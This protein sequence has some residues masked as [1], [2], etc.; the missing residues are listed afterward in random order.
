MM[1]GYEAL[2]VR[3]TGESFLDFYRSTRLGQ[4]IQ[5][6]DPRVV[7]DALVNVGWYVLRLAWFAAPWSLAAFAVAA[8]WFWATAQGRTGEIFEFA[9]ARG[10]QWG[11]L[12]TAVFIAVLS[13]ALVRAERYHLPKLFHHRRHGSCRQRCGGSTGPGRL[14]NA[15]IA[16]RLFR[17]WRG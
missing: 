1:A 15:P 5:F 10:I 17:S 12:T 13:P 14:P 6:S 16:T 4:S 7:P 3:T 2:Y 11:L 9:S 8:A